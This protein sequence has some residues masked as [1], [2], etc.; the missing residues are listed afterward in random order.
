MRSE[1]SSRWAF[2]VLVAISLV[3]LGMVI[4]PIASGLFL[5]AVLAGAL[6]PVQQWLSRKLRN[7]RNIAAGLLCA[8]V[9]VALIIPVAGVGTFIVREAIAG[10]RWVSEGLK[11]NGLEGVINRLPPRVRSGVERVQDRLQL[12]SEELGKAIT[13]R[14]TEQSS[15]AAALL[16]RALSAAGA[17]VFQAAMMLI[18]LY[19]LLVEGDQF[20]EWLERISPLKRGE[21]RELLIEFRTVSV[22]VLVSTVATAGVQALVALVGFLIARL[23]YAPFFAAVTFFFAMVPAIGAAGVCLAAAAILLA[24]GHPWHALFLALW[25]LFV[26]GLVDNVV[27]PLLAKRGMTMPGAVV[28]FALLGGLAAFGGVGLLLGPLI[29]SFF[30]ALMRIQERE[31]GHSDELPPG[32][33]PSVHGR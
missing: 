5:A 22:S 15:K 26:V 3:L 1:H 6:W 21:T 18:A 33:D 2:T 20:I 31:R 19:F 16:S 23:P 13:T 29:V 4:E 32:P 25:G 7:R 30:L 8:G 9:I 11:A 27:K 28:F 12:E 24:T 14:L 10:A 17:F